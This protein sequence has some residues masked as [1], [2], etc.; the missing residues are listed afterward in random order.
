MGWIVPVLQ[1]VFFFF[2]FFL[3]GDWMEINGWVGAGRFIGK[4]ILYNQRGIVLQKKFISRPSQRI[5]E[6]LLLWFPNKK[7]KGSPSF[8]NAG[9]CLPVLY[10]S[11]EFM[12]LLRFNTLP[13][14]TSHH[15]P[16]NQK[17]FF[18]TTTFSTKSSPQQQPSS[19]HDHSL[20]NS[21]SLIL[22]IP[23]RLRKWHHDYTTPIT[24]CRKPE[25]TCKQFSA[26]TLLKKI[27]LINP[28]N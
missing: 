27:Q 4:R 25:M 2:F 11:G 24:R 21:S 12:D 13:P 22:L 6:G 8:G 15:K 23:N 20:L 5:Q 14:Q 3:I 17:I 19:Q 28:L 16:P 10:L 1:E 26:A 18:T 9:A 7:Y